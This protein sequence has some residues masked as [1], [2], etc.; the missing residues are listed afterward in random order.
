MTREN[1]AYA[2]IRFDALRQEGDKWVG[3]MKGDLIGYNAR[4]GT[5]ECAVVYEVVDPANNDHLDHQS[6]SSSDGEGE[7]VPKMEMPPVK[8][9][10]QKKEEVEKEV[11]VAVEKVEA[12]EPLESAEAAS[13]EKE[14]KEA[15]TGS[16]VKKI[17]EQQPEE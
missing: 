10:E 16:E 5:F 17:E 14:E 2:V 9:A 13:K 12:A 8:T 4:L 15:V 7:A 1:F 11:V 6:S 3:T